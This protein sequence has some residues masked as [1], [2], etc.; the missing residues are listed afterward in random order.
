MTPE[1]EVAASILM[2]TVASY[3]RMYDALQAD[4]KGWGW[5]DDK[6]KR[7]RY[8]QA[9]KQRYAAM[10]VALAAC[11]R[12]ADAAAH[13]PEPE[14]EPDFPSSPTDVFDRESAIVSTLINTLTK[15]KG[16][17]N[18]D[19]PTIEAE[20]EVKVEQSTV[21]GATT[22]DWSKSGHIRVD[23]NGA[24]A[25][26]FF[27]PPPA[28]WPTSKYLLLR[29]KQPALPGPSLV[30]WPTCVYWQNGLAQQIG[31]NPKEE[32]I[33]SFAYDRERSIYYV[34]GFCTMDHVAARG[35]QP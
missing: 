13:T 19:A 33:V 32:T 14:P 21:W 2:D 22:I 12:E 31:Q 11:D 8:L 10:K 35:E 34:I 25:E 27:V 24:S 3:I 23:L 15:P 7:F 6:A 20:V 4:F 28:S 30:S 9:A 29:L 5:K 17:G 1:Q 26:L 16:N 18:G